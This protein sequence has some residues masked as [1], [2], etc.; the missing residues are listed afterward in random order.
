MSD[1]NRRVFL[2]ECRTLYQS[3]PQEALYFGRIQAID[4][5][6]FSIDFHDE[7]FRLSSLRLQGCFSPKDV[8]RPGDIVAICGIEDEFEVLL[9]APGSTSMF[10]KEHISIQSMKMRTKMYQTIRQYFEDLNF[11]EVYTKTLVETPALEACLDGFSTKWLKD[12][13]QKHFF[14][15]TSP[16]IQLKK[17][18]VKQNNNI[19]EIAKS[20]RNE[21]C[22]PIHRP[23]FIMLEWYRIYSGIESIEEDLRGLLSCLCNKFS[24]NMPEI[25]K[26]SVGDLFKKYI[27]MDL[28]PN[29]SFQELELQ[30]KKWEIPTSSTDSWSDLF[31]RL[32]LERIEPRLTNYS[33]LI[34]YDYPPQ[35]AALARLNSSGWAQRFEL[36]LQGMEI[37]NAYDE[38][39]DPKEHMLRLAKEN[40]YRSIEGKELHLMDNEL[41]NCL[42]GGMPPC[43]GIAVGLDRLLLYLLDLNNFEE[44]GI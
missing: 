21:E 39:T 22:S 28:L 19:F 18:L 11:V 17:I 44:L 13:R 31:H 36:Y 27:E 5:L 42:Q 33:A 2:Q 20:F 8:L 3:M 1:K 29:T 43:G 9:L 34:V 38:L 37:A 25:F 6:H 10:G 15:P 32:Y 14:L 7:V 4:S 30:C 41:L 16:E 12:Q 26:C 23:E 40:Q 24:R 35:L